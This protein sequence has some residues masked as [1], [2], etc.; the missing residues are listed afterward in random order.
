[1]T[2]LHKLRV[3]G[4]LVSGLLVCAAA[5]PA[6]PLKAMPLGGEASLT[7]SAEARL[8]YDAHEQGQLVRG[9]SYRQGLFRGIL[10]ADL[11]FNP[12]VRVYG[13]IG[14]GQVD[15]RRNIATANFQNTVSLQQLFVEARGRLGP[16]QVGAMLG[17]Q[18][19]ADGPRQLISLSD[20]PNLHR[21]W[22]GLRVYAQDRGLRVG[23]FDLRATRPGRGGF[24]EAV[25]HAERLQGLNA[26][27]LVSADGEP[28]TYLDPFLMH[29]ENP[30][31][32][33]G[34]QLG[35]D[36]RDTWGLRLWGRKGGLRFDWTLA[37]QTGRYRGREVA[38]WG[39]FAVHSLALSDQGWKPRLTAHI[40]IATGGGAY[41]SGRL[42]GFNPLY[43][44]SAYLGEGQFLALSNLLMIAPGLSVSP[45][46]ATTLSVEY[47]FARRFDA[48]DA[49]YAGGMR[50]YAGTQ[51]LPGRQIGGLLRVVGTWSLS[52]QLSLFLNHERF[53]AGE[54]LRRAGLP[55]GRYS[56]VGATWRY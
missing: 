36:V 10:G 42:E 26:S 32:R 25:N 34:G 41:G 12:Q 44:S 24:D 29:S 31:F 4:A 27:W 14:T 20:G 37:H 47:G 7:L 9:N 35:R 40:D 22:N 55:S 33:F 43:A 5:A 49:A 3:G 16:A 8:R 28:N 6:V 18:E 15:G 45:T 46:P 38:A 53:D 17:R 51:G 39:L 19:F 48:H 50:A 52:A 54:L 11:R 56:H 21:S 30:S 1:M 23:A 13:E 2:W